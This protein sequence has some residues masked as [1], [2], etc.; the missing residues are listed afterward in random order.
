M[1]LLRQ[2]AEEA[3]RLHE[4]GRITLDEWVHV[5]EQCVDGAAIENGYADAHGLPFPGSIR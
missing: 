1:S 5:V 3:F 4:E 2:V